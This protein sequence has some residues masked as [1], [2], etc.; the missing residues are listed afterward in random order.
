METWQ[1][2]A[3]RDSG[4]DHFAMKDVDE[5]IGKAWMVS[6]AKMIVL[7]SWFWELYFG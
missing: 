7:I 5:T 2:N 4:L 1:L 6:E 3:L